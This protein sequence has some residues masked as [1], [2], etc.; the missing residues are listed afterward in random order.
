MLVS[1][2][3][4]ATKCSRAGGAICSGGLV[5]T[6]KPGSECEAVAGG[7]AGT[8]GGAAATAAS[9]TDATSAD[10]VNWFISG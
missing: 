8:G 7:I 9:A 3:A 1:A 4:G 2:R 6:G 5:G 10:L